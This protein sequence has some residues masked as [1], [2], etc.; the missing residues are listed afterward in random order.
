MVGSQAGGFSALK[1]YSY[2]WDQREAAPLRFLAL[3]F[4]R[5]G[6]SFFFLV[7][8]IPLDWCAILIVPYSTFI[9]AHCDMLAYEYAVWFCSNVGFTFSF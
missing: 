7:Y 9:Q 2:I 3:I 4:G 1:V 5:F 8:K 6:S